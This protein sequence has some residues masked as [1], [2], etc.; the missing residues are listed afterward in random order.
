LDWR[1]FAELR[2]NSVTLR[3]AIGGAELRTL[4]VPFTVG[5]I[6]LAG[7]MLL[8]DRLE[9][10]ALSKPIINQEWRAPAGTEMR[11]AGLE[12]G[13]LIAVETLPGGGLTV[14]ADKAIIPDSNS[15]RGLIWL[16]RGTGDNKTEMQVSLIGKSGSVAI[17]RSGE[18]ETPQLWIKVEQASLLVESGVTIGPSRERPDTR[19]IFGNKEIDPTGRGSSF[20]VPS[21]GEMSIELPTFPDGTPSGVVSW[22]GAV[23]SRQGDTLLKLGEVGIAREGVTE[24]D[25]AACAAN[26]RYAGNMFLRPVLFPVPHGEDCMPGMLTARS[27]SISRDSVAI[28]ITGSAWQLGGGKPTDSVWSWAKKN[29]VLAIVINQLLPGAVSIILGFFAWRRG[30]DVKGAPG[31]GMQKKPSAHA[32]ARA[33][34]IK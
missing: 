33:R 29:D 27:L 15:E 28:S 6:S 31:D 4:V 12:E 25:K 21:G 19:T 34:G 2:S 13:P 24:P 18:S 23:R 5:V 16:S 26:R 8:I 14:Q 10:I 1:L 30:L 7:L 11:L 32:R 22:L 3:K 17:S 20:V 9:R